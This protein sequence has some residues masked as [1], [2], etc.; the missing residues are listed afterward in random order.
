M[1]TTAMRCTKVSSPDTP[2]ATSQSPKVTGVKQTKQNPHVLPVSISN[3]KV[4]N[5]V[6][7]VD[8]AE[9]KHDAPVCATDSVLSERGP[10]SF[11]IICLQAGNAC[12]CQAGTYTTFVTCHLPEVNA[13]V[14]I[15]P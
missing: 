12:S 5:S 4:L 10:V 13:F 3:G 7:K 14:Q 15:S 2:I 9:G 6:R 8:R 1:L 11:S